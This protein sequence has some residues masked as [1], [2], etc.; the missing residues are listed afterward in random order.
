VGFGALLRR[1]RLA[2][3]LSQEGLAERAGMSANAVGAL[4]RGHRRSPHFETISL[5]AGALALDRDQRRGFETAARADARSHLGTDVVTIGPWE[6][7]KSSNLPSA[8]TSFVG[9]ETELEEV[10]TLI[11]LHRMVTVTGSGGAGKTRIALQIARRLRDLQS[12][13]VAFVDLAPLGDSAFMSTAIA[14]VLGVQEVPGHPLLETLVAYLKSKPL[15]LIIDNCEHVLAQAGFTVECLLRGSPHLRILATSR[16]PIKAAGEHAYRLPPLNATDAVTLFADRARAVDHRFALTGKSLPF[17]EQLCGRLEGLPLAIELAAARVNVLP[18]RRIAEKLAASLRLLGGG[19]RTALPRQQ[20]MRA[21]IEWSYDLLST[22]EQR[23][24]ERLSIFAGGCALDAA[25]TVAAYDDVASAQVLD[26][27]AR[28]VDKSLLVADLDGNEPRYRMLESFRE[29]AREK[30][31]ERGEQHTLA[32]RHALAALEFAERLERN[33]HIVFDRW[34][35]ETAKE[36]DNL[37]AALR[38]TLSDRNDVLLGQQIADQSLVAFVPLAFVEGQRWTVTAAE[39]IDQNT[40]AELAA[41]LTY[42]VGIYA[43]H[44]REHERALPIMQ[45]ALTRWHQIG[46]KYETALTQ[47]ACGWALVGLGRHS[48]AMTLLEEA[49]RVTRGF[50]DNRHGW[51]LRGVAAAYAA[52]GKFFEARRYAEEALQLYLKHYNKAEIAWVYHDFNEYEYCSGNAEAALAYGFKMLEMATAAHGGARIIASTQNGIACALIALKRYDE[53]ADRAITAL[54]IAQEHQ[55]AH[56]GEALQNLAAITALRED[57]SAQRQL[58]ARR[59]AARILGYLDLR[60]A[61]TGSSR[62]LRTTKQRDNIFAFL[63]DALGSEVM[64]ALLAE[65]AAMTEDVAVG[66]A[67][68]YLAQAPAELA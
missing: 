36:L 48:E 28:L 46:D 61:A 30:V 51:A 39:L 29:Y 8:L 53:A 62:G 26:L 15:L 45:D 25:T 33:R 54:R 32:R 64:G 56:L 50:G 57:A 22:Q 4:E 41:R 31:D 43:Y 18:V 38:W 67:E 12:D 60:F 59:D 63:R 65:G 58:H 44:L 1:Y 37:R 23:V 49:L 2:A 68:A 19:T 14:S 66:K 55:E 13:A 7:T 35:E 6:G 21:T 16:E 24:F 40:P 47:T 10:T 3:G 17:V 9:R 11:N 34:A 20:A 52:A 27:I 42:D 5:L